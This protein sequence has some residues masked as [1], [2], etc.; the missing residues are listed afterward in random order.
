MCQ[1]FK[2]RFCES[3]LHTGNYA[4]SNVWVGK[5]PN[6]CDQIDVNR[7]VSAMKNTPGKIHIQC[8]VHI[9]NRECVYVP[10][11]ARYCTQIDSYISKLA[12]NEP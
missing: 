12:D 4:K 3:H 5:N 10:H 8:T 9:T 1:H 6:F 7:S 11:F 2:R